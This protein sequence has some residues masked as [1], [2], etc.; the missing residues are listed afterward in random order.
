MNGAISTLL[1]FWGTTGNSSSS[2]R[3][4]SSCLMTKWQLSAVW[5]ATA[6]EMS[7]QIMTNSVVEWEWT[8]TATAVSGV[9]HVRLLCPVFRTVWKAVLKLLCPVPFSHF[10]CSQHTH[11]LCKSITILKHISTKGKTYQQQ[12]KQLSQFCLQQSKLSAMRHFLLSR[13]NSNCCPKSFLVV[14][15]EEKEERRKTLFCWMLVPVS[16]VCLAT[17]TGFRLVIVS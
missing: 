1:F 14:E 10:L 13:V 6:T 17:I 12:Q 9:D 3:L 16:S 11:T 2:G 7:L 5:L 15:E 8:R 4:L